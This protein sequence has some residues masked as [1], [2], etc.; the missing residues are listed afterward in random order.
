MGGCNQRI[1]PCFSPRFNCGWVFYS[2]YPAR[3]P[4]LGP[5]DPSL[6]IV[7]KHYVTLD[8]LTISS[9]D[10]CLLNA[11]YHY[12]TCNHEIDYWIH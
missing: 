5:S 11:V 4:T 3:T 9:D 1:R 2:I 6:S 10:Q 7:S 12:I 8:W